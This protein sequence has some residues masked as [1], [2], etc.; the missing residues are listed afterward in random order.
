[1]WGV[2]LGLCAACCW[3]LANAA[4]Q[5]ATKRCGEVG[6]LLQVQAAGGVAVVLAACLME[7]MPGELDG[8]GA[9]ALA[10]AGA[11]ALAAY[12]G[13]F[14]ALGRGSLSSAVPLISSWSVVSA[15]VGVVVLDDTISALQLLGV[16]CAV[17]GNV[18]LAKSQQASDS[19]EDS[20]SSKGRMVTMALALMAAFGFGLMVPATDVLGEQVGRLWAI[21]MVWSVEIFLGLLAWPVLRQ[22][23]PA[24][25]LVRNVGDVWVVSRAG[26][27]EV[28]G[29]VAIS[30]G[31]GLAPVALVAPAA[32]LSTGLTVL[33]GVAVL[34]E[35][36]RP[37]GVLGAML[38]SVG[39]VLVSI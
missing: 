6:A 13:L 10:C 8:R 28:A 38:A 17:A 16:G 5:P 9:A 34:R 19:K 32:S 29:F 35:R 39:V 24:P 11:S 33:W 7:G 4:I 25:R 2:L 37:L 21:P 20:E 23:L 22:W 36:L 1:M 18:L 27:L 14:G 15:G 3:T 12:L 30:V 26:V 31:V